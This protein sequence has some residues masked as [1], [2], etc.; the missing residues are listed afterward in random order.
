MDTL[1][2]KMNIEKMRDEALELL[3]KHELSIHIPEDADKKDEYD[4][5]DLVRESRENTDG[6]TSEYIRIL[7]TPVSY[8]I[9][10]DPKTVHVPIWKKDGSKANR[11]FDYIEKLYNDNKSKLIRVGDYLQIPGETFLY[12]NYSIPCEFPDDYVTETG[13]KVKSF[14]CIMTEDPDD[15]TPMKTIRRM[16][17]NGKPHKEEV[18]RTYKTFTIGLFEYEVRTYAR[19]EARLLAEVIRK[20]NMNRVA[21]FPDVAKALR[22]TD[23]STNDAGSGDD[24]TT[25]SEPKVQTESKQ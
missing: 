25:Q 18:Y 1:L 6:E 24:K 3:E 12:C 15:P 22:V 9:G 20:Y 2:I 17:Q 14:T 19:F 21:L 7:A 16:I 23:Q 13:E 8:G 11:T 5:A 10:S 4:F